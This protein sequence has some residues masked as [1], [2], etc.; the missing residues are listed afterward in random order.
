MNPKNKYGIKGFIQYIIRFLIYIFKKRKIRKENFKEAKKELEEEYKDIDKAK[1][2][3]KQK[4][5]KDRIDNM[6]NF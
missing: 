2:A 4:D 1:D 5:V 3:E 6:F